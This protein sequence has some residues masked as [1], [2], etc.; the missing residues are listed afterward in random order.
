MTKDLHLKPNFTSSKIDKNVDL[1][2]NKTRHLIENFNVRKFYELTANEEE[3]ERQCEITDDISYTLYIAES[4]RHECPTLKIKIAE[5]EIPALIDTG[6]KMSI[7]NENL[8][9]KLRHAGSKCPELPTQ[10][11]NRVSAFNNKRKRVRKQA[12]LEVDI[13]ST[14]LEQVM[15][16]STQLLTE[17]ILGSDFLIIYQAETSFPE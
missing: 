12:L 4:R 3:R 13:D 6:C 5:E 16:L 7:L 2:L 1:N 11:V 17:V 15:L 10:H 14:K 9:K 8:Y